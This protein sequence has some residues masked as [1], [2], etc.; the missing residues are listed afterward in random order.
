M[1]HPP[2]SPRAL[3]LVGFA[4]DVRELDADRGSS[5]PDVEKLAAVRCARADDRGDYASYVSKLPP[6]GRDFVAVVSE[7]AAVVSF[8]AHDV[9]ELADDVRELAPDVKF[10]A[11]D[12]GELAFRRWEHAP[13][14][15]ELPSSGCELPPRV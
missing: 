10:L 14:G 6:V 5:S 4:D 8:D 2:P 9:R 13:D 11:D 12:R 3:A 1:H 7:L 15:W